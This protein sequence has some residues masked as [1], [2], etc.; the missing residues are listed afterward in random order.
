MK[1]SLTG[2][3]ASVVKQVPLKEPAVAKGIPGVVVLGQA[4]VLT[5]GGPDGQWLDGN[6]GT[7]PMRFKK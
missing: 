7:N 3:K 2:T 1:I 4:T 5:R 6:T